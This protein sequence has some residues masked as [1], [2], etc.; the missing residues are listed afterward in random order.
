MFALSLKSHCIPSRED[1]D[2]DE[3]EEDTPAA[4]LEVKFFSVTTFYYIVS[5]FSMISR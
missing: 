5:S 3:E 4:H 1:E 2:D